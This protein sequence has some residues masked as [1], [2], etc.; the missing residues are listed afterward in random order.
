MTSTFYALQPRW[1]GSDRYFKIYVTEQELRGGLIGGQFYDE[2]AAYRMVQSAQIFA[3][4][5]QRWA[6]RSLRQ[7]RQ[8]E[9]EYDQMDLASAEFLQRDR[10]NFRLAKADIVEVRADRKKRVWTGHSDIAGTLR[11][12]LRDGSKR[13][14]IIVGEQNLEGIVSQLGPAGLQV[15]L[16]PVPAA[17]LPATPPATP[18]HPTPGDDVLAEML[19]T[20]PPR[21][22][23]PGLLRAARRQDASFGLILVGLIHTVMAFGFVGYLAY[24]GMFHDWELNGG[25]AAH[26]A[27]RVDAVHKTDRPDRGG[28]VI[29]SYDFTFR[30][31]GGAE[32]QGRAFTT[33]ERWTVGASVDIEYLATAPAVARIAGSRTTRVG[34]RGQDMALN[35]ALPPLGLLILAYGLWGRR[36]VRWLLESGTLGEAV[37]EAVKP[38]PQKFRGH[39]LHKITLRRIGAGAPPIVTQRYQPKAVAFYQARLASKQPVFMLFDPAQPKRAL[40][41]EALV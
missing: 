41:P 11:L 28:G 20:P 8:R 19:A 36:R 4:L 15:V 12:R 33:G 10:R 7:L 29:Y 18:P 24:Q 3:P 25:Q 39:R 37:V 35:L 17:P 38:L 21:K 34:F 31:P 1:L 16:P 26:A 6:D 14:W 30:P 40:F 9:L 2:D 5:V 27:G 13:E 32:R 22:V 23:P